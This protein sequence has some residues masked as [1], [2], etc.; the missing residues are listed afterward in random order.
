M[1][2]RSGI[3]RVFGARRRVRSTGSSRRKKSSIRP[4]DCMAA[5]SPAPSSTPATTRST[6]MSRG[7]ADQLALIHDSAL[8]NT[9][10]KLTYAEL[11][12]EV[13]T[14]AAVMQDLGVVK[15]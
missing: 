12:H 2:A 13:Q 8:T 3:P 1:P 9:I 14:L 7:R 6:A 4:W 11:L 5:G 15:G 10:T